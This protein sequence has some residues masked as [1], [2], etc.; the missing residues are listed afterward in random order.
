M[1]KKTPKDK[2]Y[3][4]YQPLGDTDKEWELDETCSSLADA[5]AYVKE[6]C[7]DYTDDEDQTEDSAWEFHILKQVK[8]VHAKVEVKINRNLVLKEE[9]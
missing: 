8:V 1:K 6:K 3:V 9:Q 2:Y 7:E 4:F 5:E